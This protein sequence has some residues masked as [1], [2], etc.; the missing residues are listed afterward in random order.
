MVL[1]FVPVTPTNFSFEV[2]SGISLDSSNINNYITVKN[3]E[4]VNMNI[5]VFDT[6]NLYIISSAYYEE[7]KINSEVVVGSYIINENHTLPVV[8]V[9][10][11]PSKFSKP[12]YKNKGCAYSPTSQA[13]GPLGYSP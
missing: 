11:N 3:T 12:S 5:E 9:S 8:S 6:G 2:E 7:G 4:G 10:L 1:P 13:I